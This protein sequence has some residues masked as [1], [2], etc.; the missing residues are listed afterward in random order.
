ME[1]GSGHF[2]FAI[3]GHYHF[4][5]TRFIKDAFV[6]TA[7]GTLVISLILFAAYPKLRFKVGSSSPEKVI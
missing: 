1:H 3:I 7:I 6:K 5:V 2:Y 4:A